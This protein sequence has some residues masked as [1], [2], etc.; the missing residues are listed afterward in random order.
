MES[1][2]RGWQVEVSGTMPASEVLTGL[3]ELAGLRDEAVRLSGADSPPRIA[4]AV[5]FILEGLHLSNR[6]NKKT[7][8]RRS[9]YARA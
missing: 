6:L 8:D 4:S 5:E 1:F 2:D 7:R 9:R 3:D